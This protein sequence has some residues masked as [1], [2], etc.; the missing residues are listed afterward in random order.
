NNKNGIKMFISYEMLVL[1]VQFLNR[2]SK[3]IISI[4]LLIVIVS[5]GFEI[6][7]K[8]I[9]MDSLDF[10]KVYTTILYSKAILGV[11][12]FL[13]FFILSFITFYWIR[14]SYLKQFNPVQL[15]AVIEN[16]RY[17]YP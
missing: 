2:F 3:L 12:G 16:K 17:A 8:Y 10:S 4:L 13:L 1:I 11:S 6:A 14:Q 9:L 5:L 7:T 15:P